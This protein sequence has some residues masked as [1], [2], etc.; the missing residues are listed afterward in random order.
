VIVSIVGAEKEDEMKKRIALVIAVALVCSLVLSACTGT[1]DNGNAGNSVGGGAD[2]ASDLSEYEQLLELQK[3]PETALALGGVQPKSYEDRTS[4][5]KALPVTPKPANQ[6]MVGWAAASLGS[7]YFE[8]LRDA[9]FMEAEKYGIQI[10]LQNADFNLETQ[11]QQIDTFITNQV[12]AIILN[13]VDLHSSVEQIAK[14]ADNGIPIVVI[15]PTAAAQNYEMVTTI[16]TASTMSGFNIG[17]YC[18]EQ[19]YKATDEDYI[20]VGIMVNNLADADSNSVPC[21]W[22]SGWLYAVAEIDGTPYGSMY[23]AILDGFY[24]WNDYKKERKYDLKDKG[25]DLVQLGNA[26]GTDAAKGQAATAD[27]L[28]AAPD[29]DLFVAETD[30]AAVGSMAEMR[31][32]RKI[33]GKDIQIVTAGD[34]TDYT[35][36][37]IIAGEILATVSNNPY[38]VAISVIDMIYELFSGDNTEVTN[39]KYNNLPA[40]SFTSTILITKDNVNE[41]YPDPNEKLNKYPK[42]ERFM[43]V[44]VEEYNKLHKND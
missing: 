9:A 8:G 34:G 5:P 19:F 28:I 36:D 25:L 32:Q 30:T 40:N 21:G 2:N 44:T 20:E 29:M 18:A 11:Q 16:L 1:P 15:G 39:Q 7:S 35:L 37:S 43:P 17:V 38:P 14:A 24:I 10:D 42:F 31:Q 3:S 13:A 26:E 41:W 23:D 6:V 33:P 27:M 4:I 12:D 22:I